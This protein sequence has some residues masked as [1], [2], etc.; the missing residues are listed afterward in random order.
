LEVDVFAPGVEIYSTLPGGDQYGNQQ[1]TS[2]ASPVAA[3]LAA[4]LLSYYPELTAAQVKDILERSVRKI[5]I[6]VLKPG[7]EEEVM[8]S[9]ISKVG[10]ILNAYEALLLAATVKGARQPAAKPMAKPVTPKKG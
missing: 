1:G 3:G 7:T 8:L 2:M 6:K 10:G 5:D 9:E 4:L